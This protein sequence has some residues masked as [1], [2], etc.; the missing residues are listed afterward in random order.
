MVISVAVESC[1]ELCF[2]PGGQDPNDFFMIK[3]LVFVATKSVN[4]CPSL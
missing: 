1:R 4:K 2:A 3:S